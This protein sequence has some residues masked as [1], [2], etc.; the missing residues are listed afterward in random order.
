MGIALSASRI[1]TAKTCSWMYFAKYVMKLPDKSNDG[2]SR[3][4]IC[5]LI[6]ECLG[7]Q[8]RRKMWKRLIKSGDL[9]SEP[10]I[11]R[12]CLKHAVKLEVDD[13][14]NMDLIREMTLKGLNFDFEGTSL[15]APDEILVEQDFDMEIKEKG[16]KFRV[17]GFIDKLF[18]YKK[19]KLAIIRDFKSSKRMFEG[20]EINKNLQDYIYTLVIRRLYPKYTRVMSEFV[21]LK[22]DLSHGR[23][24]EGY[25]PMQLIEI[26]KIDGFEE[27]LDGIQKYLN[28]F[29]VEK[30][31]SGYAAD[32]PYGKGFEGPVVC[33]RCKKPGELKLD[34]TP[35]WS[36]AFKFG[37]GYYAVMGKD[38]KVKRSY[39]LGDYLDGK[40]SLKDGETLERR[41]Y[42]GCPRFNGNMI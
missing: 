21:F 19:K 22:F 34:G 6:F 5:H 23:E 15:G 32:K 35:K 14:D 1:K 2:A 9:F 42:L 29:T 20:E 12:L 4:W 36:C 27:E 3:G 33:G 16:K 38:K 13:E 10:S 41:D 11:K 31:K 30:G 8:R 37:F 25:Q 17:R 7:I 26:N 18:L 40:E 24:S 28:D 39:F